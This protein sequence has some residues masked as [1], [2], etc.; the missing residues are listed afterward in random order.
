[1]ELIDRGALLS[2]DG[3]NRYKLWRIWN[4]VAPKVLFVM[5]NPS[6]AD[7]SK[8]DNTIRKCTAMVKGWG[9]FGGYYVGNLFCQRTSKPAVLW[10]MDI[11]DSIALRANDSALKE[12]L[13]Q[14]A[15]TVVAW[16]NNGL[17]VPKRTRELLALIPEPRALRVT[18]RG[19][20]WHP[21][22]M[23]EFPKLEELQ[24]YD[25]P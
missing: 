25:L 10:T 12:M 6:T 17:A 7:A 5:L 3:Q 18:K 20:P 8:D 23:R 15:L 2:A 16:G 22:Y 9:D 24:P 4:S 19:A 14:S 13:A 1:M 21:S 11:L